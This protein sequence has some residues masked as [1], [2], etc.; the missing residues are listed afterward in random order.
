MSTTRPRVLLIGYGNPGRLDDGLGPAA[1]ATIEALAL[2]SVTVDSDYQL[3]LEDAEAASRHDVAIFVD[4]DV[5]GPEPFSVVK[6]VPVEE[7]SF[8]T[9][10]LRPEA[11]MGLVTK[12]FG[13]AT[14]GYLV[15]IR[16]Y[17]FNE[18]EESLSDKAR[19]N[20]D[21]AVEFLTDVLTLGDAAAIE[22]ELDT[23]LTTAAT[24]ATAEG[25]SPCKTERT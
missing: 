15:G 16:G 23:W 13:G 4:A 20:L 12:V 14:T 25:D 5:S 19:A 24:A 10:S 11:V 9:H 3:M 8:S 18:F 21:A 17:A 7:V 6:L 1:A 2:P 22:T